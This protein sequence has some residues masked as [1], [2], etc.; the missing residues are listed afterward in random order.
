MPINMVNDKGEEWHR[1]KQGR[2]V[3]TYFEAILQDL[4]TIFVSRFE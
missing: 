3:V 4:F 1:G 2:E